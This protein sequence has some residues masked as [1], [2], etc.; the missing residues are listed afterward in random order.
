MGTETNIIVSKIRSENKSNSTIH[1]ATENIPIGKCAN[2]PLDLLGQYD[3]NHRTNH[4]PSRRYTKAKS[5]ET[6][7][8]SKFRQN[9]RGISFNDLLSNGLAE[10]KLQAQSTL[11]HCLRSGILFTPYKYKPQRYY[12]TCLKSEILNKNI[13]V[14]PSGVGLLGTGLLRQNRITL[15][16]GLDSVIMQS[17]EGYVLPMLPKVPLHIHKFLRHGS[18]LLVTARLSFLLAPGIKVKSMKRSL[19]EL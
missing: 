18:C 11:K 17:L 16:H 8:I 5:I 2:I 4:V 15:N 14:S 12:A 3:R 6:F 13:P 10:H 9:G 7:A 1:K 19:G